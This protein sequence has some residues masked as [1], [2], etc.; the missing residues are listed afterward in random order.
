MVKPEASTIKHWAPLMYGEWTHFVVS[1][2]FYI[3]IHKH[4]SF[5][6]H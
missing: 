4:T 1:C 3:V 6:T 2:V 5:D